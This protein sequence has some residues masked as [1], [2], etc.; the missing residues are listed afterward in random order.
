MP[1]ESL[2]AGHAAKMIGFSV[3]GDFELGCLFIQNSAANWVF[4]HYLTHDLIETYTFYLLSLVV[5]K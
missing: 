3:I 4:G 2:L 5:K 1:F